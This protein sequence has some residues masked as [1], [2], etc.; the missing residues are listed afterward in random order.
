M[1]NVHAELERSGSTQW[2][3]KSLPQVNPGQYETNTT[4]H[5]HLVARFVQ[6]YTPLNLLEHKS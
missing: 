6:S 1:L 5:C 4:E 3:C 2:L